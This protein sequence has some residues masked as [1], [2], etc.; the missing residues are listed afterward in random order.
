MAI[1]FLEKR[2]RLQYLIPILVGALLVT[3]FVIWQGFFVKETISIIIEPLMRP[4]KKIEINFPLLKDPIFQILQPF[5][6]ISPPEEGIGRENPFT[7]YQLEKS[8]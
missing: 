6:K 4:P 2:Q 5:E 3:L 1:T 7:P 8:K